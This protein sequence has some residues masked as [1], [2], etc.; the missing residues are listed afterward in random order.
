MQKIKKKNDPDLDSVQD[1]VTS[2]TES[3]DLKPHPRPDGGG[4]EEK[5]LVVGKYICQTEN[6]KKGS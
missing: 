4:T 5:Y 6:W 2:N 3:T 1:Y